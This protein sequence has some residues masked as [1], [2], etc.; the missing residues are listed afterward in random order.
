MKRLFRC[1]LG[2]FWLLTGYFG[3]SYH[4]G[5][6]VRSFFVFF[7]YSF[8]SSFFSIVTF[9]GWT[10][11][12][13]TW[14]KPE[15]VAT[16]KY[17]G[18]LALPVHHDWSPCCSYM[19]GF[20]VLVWPCQLFVR[21]CYRVSDV[22]DLSL[23]SKRFGFWP[24]ITHVIVLIFKEIKHLSDYRTVGLSDRRTIGLSDYRI[25]GRTPHFVW[26]KLIY[27]L[28]SHSSSADRSFWKS[29]E[30]VWFLTCLY[31]KLSSANKRNVEVETISGRS[32][33]YTRNNSGPNNVPCGP[34]ESTSSFAD[35]HPSTSTCC[36]LEDKK[37]VIHCRV[38]PRTSLCQSLWSKRLC[39]T[40]SNALAKSR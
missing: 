12:H 38:F 10:R 27:H 29:F 16:K 5:T 9:L 18:Y 7:F 17:T 31:S 22:L 35:S 14:I 20:L 2:L 30:S 40:L 37:G 36:V 4:R 24:Y 13:A 8:I 6:L 25:I 15:V 32:L 1:H 3:Y 33:M 39:G 28:S 23:V 26:W 21:L 34:P 11:L 19:W